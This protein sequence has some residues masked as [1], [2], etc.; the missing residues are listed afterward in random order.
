[1]SASVVTREQ[2]L[3]ALRIYAE[4]I[5]DVATLRALAWI[6]HWYAKKRLDVGPWFNR[7]HGAVEVHDAFGLA[8]TSGAAA[9]EHAKGYLGL[10]RT[11]R[12]LPPGKP[13][14]GWA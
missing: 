7:E 11:S 14:Q 1:M 2:A 4:K 3:N 12:N 9:I 10:A 8:I 6:A 13:P 5:E